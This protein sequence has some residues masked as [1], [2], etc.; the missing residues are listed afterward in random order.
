MNLVMKAA[1]DYDAIV[2]CLGE[3]VYSECKKGPV[4]FFSIHVD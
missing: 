3:H 4:F 1:K 2:V